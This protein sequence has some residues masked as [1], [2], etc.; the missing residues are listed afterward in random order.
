MISVIYRSFDVRL[1]FRRYLNVLFDYLG[2]CA[3][4]LIVVC[5]AGLA[6]VSASTKQYHQRRVR[7]NYRSLEVV[8]L[9]TADRTK[10]IIS[11]DFT[12]ISY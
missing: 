6:S 3:A 2:Y 10:F 9:V 12:L 1:Q 4:V 7:I 8:L 5:P 11:F